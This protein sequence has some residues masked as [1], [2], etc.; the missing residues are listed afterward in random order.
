MSNGVRQ[1]SLLSPSLFN[2]YI[3]QISIRLNKIKVGCMQNNMLV[4]HLIYADDMCLFS[5]SAKGLQMLI[6]E[7]YEEAHILDINYNV[8]KTVCMW[9]S[10]KGWKL[11]KLPELFLNNSTL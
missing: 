3:D 8:S 2:V 7:C 10:P 4:N 9:I 6:N 1:G 11:A 5:P